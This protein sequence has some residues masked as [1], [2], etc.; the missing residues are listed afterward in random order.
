MNLLGDG[1]FESGARM[2]IVEDWLLI[3]FQAGLA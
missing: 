2:G 1:G 3:L